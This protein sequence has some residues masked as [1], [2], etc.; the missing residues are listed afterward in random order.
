MERSW[1]VN[2]DKYM[3]AK[4]KTYADIIITSFHIKKIPEEKLPC[5]CLSVIMLDSVIESYEKYY[6]QWM[7]ICRR[8]DKIWELYWWRIRWWLW[9][10]IKLKY[11]N[12]IK[13]LLFA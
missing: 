9:W 8:K 6:P 11:F 5:K 10:W 3:K 12:T 4:I 13:A 1:E 2:D 7:Q